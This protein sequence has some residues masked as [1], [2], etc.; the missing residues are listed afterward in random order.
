VVDWSG[1]NG[2]VPV[3]AESEVVAPVE[4]AVLCASAGSNG[5]TTARVKMTKKTAQPVMTRRKNSLRVL[6]LFPAVRRANMD[7]FM[8]IGFGY[9]E[10]DPAPTSEMP[11]PSDCNKRNIFTNGTCAQLFQFE[12]QA[13][14]VNK[15]P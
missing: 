8:T 2:G 7:V 14:T 3:V 12:S 9:L 13:G 10:F 4:A 15:R 11:S 1:L 5:M 6:F